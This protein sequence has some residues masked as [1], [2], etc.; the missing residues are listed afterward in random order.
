MSDVTNV[1]L[2]TFAESKE[3]EKRI[4]AFPGEWTGLVRV[5]SHAGGTKCMECEVW[6]AAF[7]YLDDEA[8][9]AHLKGIT[10]AWPESVQLLLMHQDD[11]RFTEV[12][13]WG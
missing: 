10:W 1:L 5:D 7:N 12:K 8:L 3:V 9:I 11:E 2:M 6:A 4:E 13:L